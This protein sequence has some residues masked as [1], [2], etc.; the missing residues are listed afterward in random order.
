MRKNT[1][2]TVQ[3]APEGPDLGPV[4]EIVAANGFILAMALLRGRVP[5]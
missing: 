2:Q 3:I 4:L 1:T 5:T